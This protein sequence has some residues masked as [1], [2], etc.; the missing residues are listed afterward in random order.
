[1]Y[2]RILGS[3]CLAFALSVSMISMAQESDSAPAKIAKKEP[4]LQKELLGVWLLAGKPDAEIEP[5]PGARMKFFGVGHWVITQ[6]D[7]ET[8]EVK[9]HHGG[10]YSLDGD[11]YTERITYASDN[12]KEMI[13]SEFKFTITVKD[14]KYTQIGDG[15]PFNELWSWPAE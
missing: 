8:G 3:I 1:M 6:S 13:G 9:F 11:K 4:N 12:T 5:Q 14:G 10:T 2:T 7:P 15:N